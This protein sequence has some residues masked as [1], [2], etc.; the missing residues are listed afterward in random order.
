MHGTLQ[1][2]QRVQRL[3]AVVREGICQQAQLR[4]QVAMVGLRLPRWRSAQLLVECLQRR[5]K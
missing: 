3:R 4:A 2:L 5:L 1:A